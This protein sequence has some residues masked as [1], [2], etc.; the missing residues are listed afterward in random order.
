MTSRFNVLALGSAGDAAA[1][2]SGD[3]PPD[4]LEEIRAALAN[5][6]ERVHKLEGWVFDQEQAPL[7]TRG[8]RAA[9]KPET[10]AAFMDAVASF[11]LSVLAILEEHEEW[12]ADTLEEVAAA[13]ASLG[14]ADC[15]QDD[16]SPVTFRV[17]RPPAQ[18]TDEVQS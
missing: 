11:G 9:A 16:G 10:P 4:T 13:A 18:A 1:I 2:L 6:L 3:N 7:P 12:S 17:V 8:R 14:L 5:A 15:L